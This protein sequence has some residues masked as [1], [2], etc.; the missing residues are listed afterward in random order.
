MRDLKEYFAV[1]GL[2]FILISSFFLGGCGRPMEVDR[3]F[4][5]LENFDHGDIQDNADS[6]AQ[7]ELSGK[8]HNTIDPPSLFGVDGDSSGIQGLTVEKH[9]GRPSLDYITFRVQLGVS[10]ETHILSAVVPVAKVKRGEIIRLNG[11]PIS[12]NLKCNGSDCNQMFTSVTHGDED[13]QRKTLLVLERDHNSLDNSS[14]RHIL[15]PVDSGFDAYTSVSNIEDFKKTC[16]GSE[17]GSDLDPFFS[18]DPSSG[19]S[20]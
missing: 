11:G 4:I 6:F 16:S 3:D 1:Y 9:L 13:E 5:S 17:F 20:I 8:I 18:T 7:E 15:T 12:L 2:G 10:C 14:R 19:I